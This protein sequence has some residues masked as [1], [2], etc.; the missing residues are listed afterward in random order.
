MLY[1]RVQS[2]CKFSFCKIFEFRF[3]WRSV[4]I[5]NLTAVSQTNYI[6]ILFYTADVQLGLK[7]YGGRF[8]N[9]RALPAT[10]GE[11]VLDLYHDGFGKCQI[12]QEIR[13]SP[14]FVQKEIEVLE[15]AFLVP[16]SMNKL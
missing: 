9:G 6:F 7:R 2:A 8:D 10:Y 3:A 15:L 13:S 11:Q 16:K 14:G 5:Y 1:T 4:S 12:A